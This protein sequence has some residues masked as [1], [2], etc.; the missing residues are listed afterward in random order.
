MQKIDLG[1]KADHISD[2]QVLQ[3]LSAVAGMYY[4]HAAPAGHL[5]DCIIRL[6]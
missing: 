1:T 6:N 3:Q 4:A 5:A 2:Q